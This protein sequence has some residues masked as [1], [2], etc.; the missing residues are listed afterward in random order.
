MR[1]IRQ[2]FLR[3]WELFQKLPRSSSGKAL[4][5]L[6]RIIEI[7]C[8]SLSP[9]MRSIRQKVLGCGG[10]FKSPCGL[11]G[12]P[13]RARSIKSCGIFSA[14]CAA[15]LDTNSWL[16][17]KRP[18]DKSRWPHVFIKNCRGMLTPNTLSAARD[19][20][21]RHSGCRFRP[22]GRRQRTAPA[23]CCPSGCIPSKNRR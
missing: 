17:K 23:P 4:L 11:C 18:A 10:F 14:G 7:R 15:V 20:Q 9:R 8:T 12:R 6:K 19:S 16:K 2:K 21:C 5:A 13:V 22:P 1:S 3:V